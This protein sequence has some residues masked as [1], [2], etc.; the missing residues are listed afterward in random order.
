MELT[1]LVKSAASVI[2]RELGLDYPENRMEEFLRCI[3]KATELLPGVTSA[4]QILEEISSSQTI[5]GHYYSQLSIALTINETYFFR[6]KPAMDFLKDTIVKE[7]SGHKGEYVVWSAGCSSGEEPYTIAILLKESLNANDLGKVRIV[8]TDISDRAL[9]KAKEG[10]YTQ[11]SFRET[12]ENIKAKYFSQQEGKWQIVPEIREMVSFGHLN[13]LKDNYSR[14]FK[15]TGHANLIFCRNVLMYFSHE[16]IKTVSGKFHDTLEN[17]GWLVTSQVELNNNLFGLFSRV[18][19]HGALFYKKS[20]QPSHQHT[21]WSA[22]G[23]DTP[24]QVQVARPKLQSSQLSKSKPI[25]KK[26]TVSKPPPG[27]ENFVVAK[28]NDSQ[29]LLQSALEFAGKGD[30]TKA[31]GILD[32]LILEDELNPEIFYLYGVIHSEMGNTKVAAEM[33]KKSL[34]LDPGNILSAYMLGNI[35]KN[36]GKNDQARKY[37][38]NAYAN[39]SKLDPSAQLKGSGGLTTARLAQIIEANL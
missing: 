3:E 4:K 32:N 18:Y 38:I 12:P 25:P 10:L 14:L 22:I 1:P 29:G 23:K 8:A 19:E 34:Y 21:S 9:A 31:I 35:Y 28:K 17:N 13:L 2:T 6:E 39:L 33:F 30:F 7:I 27:N 24:G 26:N 36:E 16:N 5:P 20:S 11:W 15:G 37:F